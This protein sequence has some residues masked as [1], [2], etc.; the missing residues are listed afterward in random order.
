MHSKLVRKSKLY[1]NFPNDPIIT[2]SCCKQKYKS[3]STSVINKLNSL[4]DTDSNAYW[5]LLKELQDDKQSDQ[6]EKISSEQWVK[7]FSKLFSI[8][9]KFGPKNKYFEKLL[10]MSEKSKTFSALDF[11]ITDIEAINA[12]NN[13][14]NKLD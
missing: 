2:G 14:K 13:L 4:H 10:T 9:E 5:K 11:R 8:D 1:S 7:H 12:I 6:S 3:F